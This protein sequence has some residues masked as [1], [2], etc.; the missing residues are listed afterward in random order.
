[1]FKILLLILLI[2]SCGILGII[3]AADYRKR[4]VEINNFRSML[5]LLNSEINYRK[6][7]ISLIFQR[8]S[9]DDISATMQILNKCN[10]LMNSNLSFRESWE[11]AVE[12]VCSKSSLKKEDIEIIR[13]LGTY[14]GQSNS[15]EQKNFIK[16]TDEKLKIQFDEAMIEKKSKGKMYGGLGFSIGIII[17]VILI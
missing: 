15:D 16:L 9:C 7:P 13:S 1:M 14:L 4:V 3:K 2:L 12:D 6:D 17:A 5:S 10:S 11:L 8:L